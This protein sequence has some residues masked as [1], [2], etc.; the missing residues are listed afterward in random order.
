MGMAPEAVKGG[1][2]SHMMQAAKNAFNLEK[3]K[4]SQ[5][6][7]LDEDAAGATPPKA[8]AGAAPVQMPQM[9]FMQPR[10]QAPANVQRIACFSCKKIFGVPVGATAVA[11]PHCGAANN[12]SNIQSV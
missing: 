1:L 8:A 3:Q 7:K 9:P 6:I 10:P 12:V 11:C 5:G 4:I 2:D